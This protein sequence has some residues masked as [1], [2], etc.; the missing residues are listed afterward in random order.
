MGN[1]YFPKPFRLLMDNTTAEAFANNSCF[2][3]KLKHIDVSQRWVRCL[4]DH[5][6]MIPVHVNTHDNLADIFTKVLSRQ[7]FEKHRRT[8][9]NLPAGE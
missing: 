9:L 1:V 5:N 8:V 4:R 6:I 7:P 3:S 2:K